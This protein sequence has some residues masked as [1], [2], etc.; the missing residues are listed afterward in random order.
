MPSRLK[1]TARNAFWSYISMIVSLLLQFVSRTVFIYYLG[2]G[3]LGINGLFSNILG[4][5][6]FAELGIGTAINFSLYKPVAENNTE[7]IKAYMY[8]YKW[9]YRVIALIVAVLGLALI[10]FLDVLVTDPGNVGNITVYY[11]IY[12]FNTV[13]SYFVSY[14]YSLVNAAQKNYIYTNINL[15][16]SATTTV[17]QIISLLIWKSF[18]AYLLVAAIFGVFQKIFIS[19]YFDKLYP[20]LKEK[21]VQKL[22][23]EEKD[24]LITKIKALIVHKIGDVSVHQTDSIIV[25]AFVSTKIVGLLSNYNLLISTV[26]SCINVLFNSV[27][28]SLGN[29]VATESK[30]YQYAVFKKYRF[31]GFWLYGFTAIALGVLMTPFITLWIG[32]RM[33]VDPVVVNLL[34]IDYYM[35]GQRICLNNIK[36]AAGIY[37]PDKYVALLQAIV[38]LVS[39]IALVKLIGLPGVYV[40]T[41][42]QGTLST[43]LKPILSY[44]L[45]FGVSSRYYFIDSLKYGSAVIISYL[46]CNIIKKV[47]LSNVTIMN[48]ICMM[49]VVVVIPNAVF[50]LLF[51]K[52]PEFRFMADTARSIVSQR[53]RKV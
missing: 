35:I 32:G 17:I 15:I 2:E 21:N 26:S 41:L 39:S 24:T 51:H 8:Y 5:L 45:M 47:F 40:G 48:F 25:S 36:S 28:G 6:S 31:I 29:M 16:I 22:K 33:A 53:F 27:T 14:K 1:M 12:L 9:A 19:K 43:I 7:K 13:S 52:C 44:K 18:L 4:I 10:P 11:I 38:N 34:V 42:I 37:E 20:Y 23:S 49:A 3:Y 50:V 30:E 46:I